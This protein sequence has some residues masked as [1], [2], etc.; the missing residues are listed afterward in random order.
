MKKFMPALVIQ[1]LFQQFPVPYTN[2]LKHSRE[3]YDNWKLSI[4]GFQLSYHYLQIYLL[5]SQYAKNKNAR[6]PASAIYIK[7]YQIVYG[8]IHKKINSSA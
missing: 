5:M 7:K 3:F 4:H 6:K 8:I 1:L 2:Q